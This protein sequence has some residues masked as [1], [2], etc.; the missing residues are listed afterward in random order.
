VED[1]CCQSSEGQGGGGGGVTLW[2]GAGAAVPKAAG[3]L[4]PNP[5]PPSNGQVCVCVGEQS[6]ADVPQGNSRILIRITRRQ[7]VTWGHTLGGEGAGSD[8]GQ[9][10]ADVLLQNLRSGSRHT[11]THTDPLNRSLE[12]PGSALLLWHAR[13]LLRAT[14]LLYE[15]DRHSDRDETQDR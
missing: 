10:P 15:R 2:G 9:S 4:N 13:V 11:D 8:S 12:I 1:R 14:L 3:V 5:N 7:T 6:T